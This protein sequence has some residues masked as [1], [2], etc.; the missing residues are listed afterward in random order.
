MW[1]SQ[2][3]V[4]PLRVKPEKILNGKIYTFMKRIAHKLISDD[5]FNKLEKYLVW[6]S[7]NDELTKNVCYTMLSEKKWELFKKLYGAHDKIEIKKII[8]DYIRA[9]PYK[10]SEEGWVLYSLFNIRI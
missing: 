10:E 4:T 2:D 5:D 8:D 3:N 1:L 9:Y 7:Q 6:V